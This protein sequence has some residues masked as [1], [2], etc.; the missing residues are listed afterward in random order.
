MCNKL[1]GL[2]FPPM[3]HSPVLF[4]SLFKIFDTFWN[5]F[6]QNLLFAEQWNSMILERGA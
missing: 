6:E 4:I 2:Y 1:Y 3:Q 5:L